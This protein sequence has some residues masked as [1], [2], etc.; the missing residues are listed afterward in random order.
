[1]QSLQKWLCEMSDEKLLQFGRDAKYMSSPDANLGEA[2][3]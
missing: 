2:A 3:A 1:M